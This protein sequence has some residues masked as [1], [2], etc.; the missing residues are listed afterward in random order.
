MNR[1]NK[2]MK[3]I[4]RKDAA[5]KL[6]KWLSKFLKC[7]HHTLAQNTVHIIIKYQLPFIVI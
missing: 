7:Q 3:E 1:M 2:G 6:L 5:S 4:C